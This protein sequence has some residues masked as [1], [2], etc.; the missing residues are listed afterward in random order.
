VKPAIIGLFFPTVNALEARA[1]ELLGKEEALFLASGTMGNLCAMLSW[2]P[3]GGEIIG[4]AHS[5][6]LPT[7]RPLPSCPWL[8]CSGAGT[9]R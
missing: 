6:S 3:R 4:G 9:G 7:W 8:S 5:H 2:V 1:A